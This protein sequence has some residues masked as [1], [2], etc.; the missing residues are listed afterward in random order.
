MTKTPSTTLDREDLRRTVAGV[1]DVGT[2]SV[3]D[4]SRLEDLGA[5]SLLALELVVVL[6]RKYQVRFDETEMREITG[7]T[8]V[9]DLLATKLGA[10]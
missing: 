4:E 3:S 7:F 9:H 5:D 6:E 1:L 10:V 8:A 2:D